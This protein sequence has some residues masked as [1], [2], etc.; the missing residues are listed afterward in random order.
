MEQLGPDIRNA[1]A[2]LCFHKILLIRPLENN[3]YDLFDTTGI[4][5]LDRLC[6]K[7]SD[8]HEN[9]SNYNFANA[10]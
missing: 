7:F 2:Y 8:L 6:I 9:K 1:D 5:R 3:T 4:R 10:F